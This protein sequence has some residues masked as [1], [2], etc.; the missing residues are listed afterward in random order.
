MSL[1]K[2][3]FIL[4]S[5]NNVTREQTTAAIFINSNLSSAIGQFWKIYEIF[6][7]LYNVILEMS[8]CQQSNVFL[9]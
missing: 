8:K 4:F 2:I 5:P 9:K 3:H 6:Y 1:N 7:V